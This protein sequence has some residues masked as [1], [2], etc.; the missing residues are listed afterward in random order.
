M[1]YKFLDKN[2][3]MKKVLETGYSFGRDLILIRDNPAEFNLIPWVGGP[4]KGVITARIGYGKERDLPTKIDKTGHENGI[5]LDKS[6][7]ERLY[8]PTHFVV[9]P[10]GV[11]G[12]ERYKDGPTSYQ[13]K[14]F[15]SQYLFGQASVVDL[16]EVYYREFIEEL[17]KS[18]RVVS[19]YMKMAATKYVYHM[20]HK[21]EMEN[22]VSD[23]LG[24]YVY[25]L[26]PDVIEIKASVDGRIRKKRLSKEE[27]I[28]FVDKLRKIHDKLGI[29]EDITIKYEDPKT[30]ELKEKN[31]F[32]DKLIVTKKV[33]RA[34]EELSRVDSEQMYNR[35]I[36]A[37]NDLYEK[38]EKFLKGGS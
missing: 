24:E 29:I 13:L 34:K 1:R 27:V 11:V 37:Y 31:I 36:E 20:T 10:N 6:R 17:L 26:R 9:F 22:D 14:Y 15:L 2:I 30:H 18:P 21:K 35:I 32:E 7:K 8:Y 3:P 16:M 19:M 38:I 5:Q 25:L 12:M 4:E 23:L 28:S 33:V